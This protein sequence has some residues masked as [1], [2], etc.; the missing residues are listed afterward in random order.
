MCVPMWFSPHV[1]LH[2]VLS[3][4]FADGR[5]WEI[6]APPRWVGGDYEVRGTRKYVCPRVVF[7]PRGFCVVRA[8]RRWPIGAAVRS[9]WIQ[10]KSTL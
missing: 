4:D 3:A 7:S 8:E 5:R 9:A 1:V 10:G 2:V 6:M